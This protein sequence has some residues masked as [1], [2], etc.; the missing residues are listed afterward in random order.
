MF[1]DEEWRL[2]KILAWA[3]TVFLIVWL[4]GQFSLGFYLPMI[5]TLAA[6]ILVAPPVWK[7][8]EMQDDASPRLRWGASVGLAFIGILLGST[9]AP[10]SYSECVELKLA[11]FKEIG[12]FPY[13]SDGRPA[14]LAARN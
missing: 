3:W 7:H 9:S 11:Y 10:D 12:S 1:F 2:L 5:L 4:F 8:L 14:D 6:A 13:L